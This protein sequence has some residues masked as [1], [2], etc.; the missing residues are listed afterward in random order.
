MSLTEDQRDDVFDLVPKDMVIWGDDEELPH[1]GHMRYAQWA[2]SLEHPQRERGGC[3]RCIG[4]TCMANA[5]YDALVTSVIREL[6]KI[7]LLKEPP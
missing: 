3:R 4:G 6:D 5:F 7:G 1:F 2:E